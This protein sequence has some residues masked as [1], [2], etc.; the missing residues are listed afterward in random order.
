MYL[1]SVYLMPL[2]VTKFPRPSLRISILLAIKYRRW[3]WPGNEAI[4]H[5]HCDDT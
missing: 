3:E 5:W 2:H 4:Y 1:T